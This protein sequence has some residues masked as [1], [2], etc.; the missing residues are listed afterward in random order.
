MNSFMAKDKTL[1]EAQSE[2][3]RTKTEDP[4]RAKALACAKAA[5][6]KKAENIKIL[7]LS[8]LSSFTDYFVICS[9]LSDRQVHAIAD[10]VEHEMESCGYTL[11]NSEG[12]SDGRWVLLDFGDVIVHVFLDALREYYDLET[13]WSDAP[14]IPVPAEYYGPTPSRLN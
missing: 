10:S 12:Y 8:E 6:E 7:D 11:V 3:K 13:L 9:A 4:S 5:I 2:D 1:S 14:R